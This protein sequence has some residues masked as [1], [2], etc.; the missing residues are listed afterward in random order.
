MIVVARDYE[1]LKIAAREL[2]EESL[3]ADD[4]ERLEALAEQAPNREEILARTAEA[5]RTLADGYYTRIAYLVLLERARELGSAF[6]LE[7]LEAT[8]FHGLVM[9]EAARAEFATDHPPCPG[10]G[11][12]RA[13]PFATRCSKC[14]WKKQ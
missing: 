5:T 14:G 13:T 10:C 12:P 4:R 2:L 3:R 9:L 11:A 8:E 7:E 6:R 1:G